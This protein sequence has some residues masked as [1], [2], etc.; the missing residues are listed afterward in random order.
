MLNKLTHLSRTP[1]FIM[2]YYSNK[3]Y[4]GNSS[5]NN[6]R[7]FERDHDGYAQVYTDGACSSNGQEGA[8]AG[9]GVYWGENNR[10]NRSQPVSGR[11]TNNTAEIQAA[12][13]AMRTARE[14]GLTKLAINTD[15]KFLM[16]SATKWI[17]GWQ[18]NGWRTASGEPVKNQADFK[19]MVRAQENLDVKWNYVKAHDGSHGNE[20]ADR[21][22]KEGAARYK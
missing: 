5:R 2:S 9:Y 21:L 1:C 8:R 18:D 20:M 12:T 17:P 15:S 19:E 11:A 16:D 6:N 22:A 7:G 4:Y 14:N 3:N 13:E 10:F